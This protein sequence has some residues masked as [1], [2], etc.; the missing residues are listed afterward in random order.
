MSIYAIA[1]GVDWDNHG[2]VHLPIEM[3]LWHY[4][5]K[6][7]EAKIEVYIGL[8]DGGVGFISFVPL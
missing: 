4:I 1:D 7:V 2:S 6:T 5:K 8:L 3:G